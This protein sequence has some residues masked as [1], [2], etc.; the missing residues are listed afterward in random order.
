VEATHR[1]GTR[2]ALQPRFLVEASLALVGGGFA[3]VRVELAT[4]RGPLSPGIRNGRDTGHFGQDS[5]SLYAPVPACGVA[6]AD[7]SDRRRPSICRTLVVLFE[8]VTKSLPFV[9]M[10]SP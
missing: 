10:E 9:P 5:A 8:I 2:G 7:N 3:G 1:I 4:I 6:A